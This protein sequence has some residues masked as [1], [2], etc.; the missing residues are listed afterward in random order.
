VVNLT[1]LLTVFALYNLHLDLKDCNGTHIFDYV[2]GLIHKKV[3]PV[4]AFEVNSNIQAGH[5]RTG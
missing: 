1:G 5:F 3:Y 4:K 2:F